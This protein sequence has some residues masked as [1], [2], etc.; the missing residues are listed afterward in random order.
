MELVA[1]VGRDLDLFLEELLPLEW[2]LP[3]DDMSDGESRLAIFADVGLL[4][5][6]VLQV[7][8]FTIEA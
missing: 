5:L 2:H 1:V 3:L 7:A 8:I 6:G 4:D